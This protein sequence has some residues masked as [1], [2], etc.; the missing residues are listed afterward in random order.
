MTD[1]NPKQFRQQRL[2]NPVGMYRSPS[3]GP[4]GPGQPWD[5]DPPETGHQLRA[6]MPTEE[7]IDTVHK[8]DSDIF[9]DGWSTPE[10]QWRDIRPE[11]VGVRSLDQAVASRD[12]LPPLRVQHPSPGRF[13]QEHEP[14]LWDGHHRLAAYEK[15]G[16]TEVPVWES[17]DTHERGYEVQ[18]GHQAGGGFYGSPDWNHRPK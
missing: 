10:E 18:G 17:F 14:E 3:P 11:K 7:V 15:A 12:P 4:H 16:H 5:T 13:S 2:F 1:L 9:D 8:I 6:L